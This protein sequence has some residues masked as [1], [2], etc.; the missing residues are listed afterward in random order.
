MISPLVKNILFVSIVGIIFFIIRSKFKKINEVE[1]K[2]PVPL[3]NNLKFSIILQWVGM[4]FLGLSVLNLKGAPK[5]IKRNDNVQKISFVADYS[6]SMTAEDV[7]TSRYIKSLHFLLDAFPILEGS[8]LRLSIFGDTSYKLVPFTKDIEFLENKI[9]AI[10]DSLFPGGGSELHLALKEL[11]LSDKDQLPSEQVFVLLSDF[12]NIDVEKLNEIIISNDLKVILVGVGSKAGGYLPKTK[13]KQLTGFL[14]NKKGKI[15]SRFGI[16]NFEEIKSFKKFRLTSRQNPIDELLPVIQSLKIKENN[17]KRYDYLRSRFFHYFLYF[18]SFLILISLCIKSFSMLIDKK[19]FTSIFLFISFN[20][21]ST[22]QLNL[23]SLSGLNAFG[24]NEIKEYISNKKE[25]DRLGNAKIIFEE[26]K[27][28]ADSVS[29]KRGSE[30]NLGT[31][32]ILSGNNLTGIQRLKKIY[33]NDELV[34]KKIRSNLINLLKA[35][36]NSKSS[37]DGSDQS[38][39]D[40]NKKGKQKQGKTTKSGKKKSKFNEA[41]SKKDRNILEKLIGDDQT[42]QGEY[43][44]RKIRTKKTNGVKW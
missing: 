8:E 11:V 7:G 1:N 14:A 41:L 35:Q 44:K 22:D 15:K 9:M 42:A 24:I 38:K 34:D 16:E 4:I 19:T 17:L 10:E 43:I 37:G 39:N 26:N 40:Q 28:K 5:K 30:F 23:N 6:A 3:N 29:N 36:K 27:E 12:E 18:G 31:A 2:L 33:G 25:K 21:E 20:A 13:N 32:E